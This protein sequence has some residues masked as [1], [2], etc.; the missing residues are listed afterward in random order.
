[1]SSAPSLQGA[2]AR[3]VHPCL[4]PLP[5]GGDPLS[6]GRLTHVQR[7]GVILQAAGLLSLLER[8]GWGLTGWDAAR[9]GRDG[10]RVRLAVTGRLGPAH[11]PRP[12]QDLLRELMARLF[13]SGEAALRGPGP[14]KSAARTLAEHWQPSLVPLAPDEAVAQLLEAAPFLW[15]PAFA[16]DRAA[17]A[18]ELHR[19]DVREETTVVWVAGPRPFRQRVLAASPGLAEVRALL[20]GAEA[21]RLWD[22]EAAGDPGTLAAEGRWHAALASWERRPPVLEADRVER[23]RALAAL[24]RFEAALGALAGLGSPAALLARAEA[25]V[26]LGQF[27]AALAALRHL[28]DT[29]GARLSPDEA[30]EV[31]DVAARAFANVKT[32]EEA[33][34]WL[35]RALTAAGSAGTRAGLRARIAAAAAAW[36]RCDLPAMDRF[37]EESRAA[38]EHPDLAWRWHHACALRELETDDGAKR[39]IS[40]VEAA[41]R[42]RR[43]LPRHQAADLWNEA[44]RARAAAGDLPGAERAFLHQVRLLEGCDG[45]R[46]ATLA[47]FNLAEIRLRRG[48]LAGVREILDRSTAENRRA[49]NLRGLTQDAELWARLELVLGRP[50]AALAVCR[51]ALDDQERHG[52]DWRRSELSL[53]AARALGWLGRPAEAAAALQE[54][55]PGALRELEPE[56][57]PALYALAGELAAAHNELAA[58]A[59]PGLRTLWGT[60]LAGEPPAAASWSPLAVLE[61]YRA[62]R[63]AVDAERLL[64][65]AVPA[66]VR[67]Q[68]STALRSAGSTALAEALEARDHGPWQIAAALLN[69]LSVTRG[70]EPQP[71]EP[72]PAPLLEGRPGA[73]RLGRAGEMSG[74]SPVFLAALE[75]LDRLAAGDFPLLVLGESGTGKELAARRA[76]R[77][78]A[79]AAAPFV[80]V[81]CA[82]LSETLLLSDLFGHVRGAFTGADR[83]RPG[84]FQTADGG[85]VFLDEIG[86]LPLTAQGLLLRVLQEGEVR[87]LGESTPRK[88]NVRVL[89]ATHRDLAIMVETK[90]FR[91]DLY[92]RLRVGRV[93]LPPL[94][95]RGE[96]VLRLAERFLERS[97]A[98]LSREARS[99]LC[100]HSWPG[101]IRELQNVLSAAVALAGGRIIHPEHLELPEAGPPPGL[102]YQEQVDAAR[103]RAIFGALEECGGNQSAA[104][105]R[106][107]L[108]RQ[109]FHH[110]LQ[111]LGSPID[112]T[113][114]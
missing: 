8:A 28:K 45:P 74:E 15:E 113:R 81:N 105:R 66:D 85:T 103:R 69:L 70:V 26:R 33:A 97:G 78:S 4:D 2:V 64:P 112:P 76:H 55:P 109:G 101:N 110:I 52:L 32:P 1:M 96:D 20:S 56:E 63:L 38:L 49:G 86:D 24:G 25:Q 107:G 46:K 114:R 14:A 106:L 35:R 29:K 93:E 21:R 39:A 36:D 65:G 94:R 61:P 62:A 108:S 54:V 102:S 40:H 6:G 99:S 43:Y 57:R 12:C 68:A 91:L 71:G 50:E 73:R 90:T 88:I 30:A 16:E 111:D 48:R 80:A 87:R 27:S 7:L 77:A 98:Q 23:A 92:H 104:A 11:V 19:C 47:L 5:N 10:R 41:L 34:P 75:R 44:G 83:D 42:R 59:D 82:A 22:G 79:R 31:A 100:G 37:L 51:A 84:V 58:I 9:L 3:L 89:A 13:G 72:E 95:N 18:G 60:L 53:L 67:R 17:L